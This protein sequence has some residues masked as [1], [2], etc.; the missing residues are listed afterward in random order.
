MRIDRATITLVPRTTTNCLDLAVMFYGRHLVSILV[1][2]LTVA[3]PFCAVMYLAASQEE[4]GGWMAALIVIMATSP[5]GVLIGL[6]AI[7]VAFGEPFALRQISQYGLSQLLRLLRYGMLI[8]AIIFFGPLLFFLG[9][10]WLIGI[11]VLLCLFPGC[12]IAVRQGFFV[13][14]ACLAPLTERLQGRRIKELVKHEAGELFLRSLWLFVF[15]GLLWVVVFVTIDVACDLFLGFPI[16]LGR[17]ATAVS[18]LK[19]IDFFEH[20]RESIST[21]AYMLWY[22]PIV[23]TAIVATMLLVY[24]VGR[25]AWFFCLIDARVRRDCWDVELAFVNEATRLEGPQ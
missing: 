13:E 2:W 12:W 14:D 6:G 16:L 20:M 24:P 4:L 21:M 17:V 22:D 25:L 7:P 9:G 23:L 11:G 1:L 10:G 18:P 3:I 19:G 15:C 5:L 8:R